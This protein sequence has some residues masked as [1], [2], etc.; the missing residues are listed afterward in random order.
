MCVLVSLCLYVIM[1][2][3]LCT[4]CHQTLRLDVQDSIVNYAQLLKQGRRIERTLDALL[5]CVL[6]AHDWVCLW[7]MQQAVEVVWEMGYPEAHLFL[8]EYFRN[9]LAENNVFKVIIVCVVQHDNALCS[10]HQRWH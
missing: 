10:E 8:Q 7:R 1:H 3:C 9:F 6:Q 4:F 2:M 5:G